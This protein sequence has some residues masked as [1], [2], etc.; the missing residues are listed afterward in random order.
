MEAMIHDKPSR[1]KTFAQNFSK[2]FVLS[3]SPENYR[4][5]NLCTTSTKSTRVSGTV[6][7]KH[8]YITNPETTPEDAM[9]SA[10]NRM[11]ETLQNHTPINMCKEDLEDLR[12]LDTIF[13]K[14]AQTNT[15]VKIKATPI[16]TPPRVLTTTLYL[17]TNETRTASLQERATQPRVQQTILLTV[18]TC[19]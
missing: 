11:M 7:F 18:L 8:N 9:I 15:D 12:R 14:A 10:D 16:R 17:D 19:Q 4:C 5:W 2:G 6:F 13:T 3:S 1:Q